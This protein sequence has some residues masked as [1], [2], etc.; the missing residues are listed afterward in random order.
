MARRSYVFYVVVILIE[1]AEL[2][3]VV[4]ELWILSRKL[5]ELVGRVLAPKPAVFAETFQ[6]FVDV[7][8][9]ALD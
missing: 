8:L 6:E 9:S 1:F 2:L 3:F 7:V 5:L 4:F